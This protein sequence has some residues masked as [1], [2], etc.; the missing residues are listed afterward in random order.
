MSLQEDLPCS[1]LSSEVSSLSILSQEAPEQELLPDQAS[2]ASRA[3]SPLSTPRSL[4]PGIVPKLDLSPAIALHM[5]SL[6]GE[7]EEEEEP[8]H[9]RQEKEEEGA[10]LRQAAAM[11]SFDDLS[12]PE[13]S[14][15]A[16]EAAPVAPATTAA[17]TNAGHSMQD[18]TDDADHASTTSS[19][20]SE[21]LAGHSWE[22]STAGIAQ[23]S[24]SMPAA[25]EASP[26][27]TDE[28]IR[29]ESGET[30]QMASAPNQAESALPPK[31]ADVAASNSYQAAVISTADAKA[32]AVGA[33]SSP[34][35][36]AVDIDRT[37]LPDSSLSDDAAEST[38]MAQASRTL[39]AVN[40]DKSL[41]TASSILEELE[42]SSAYSSQEASPGSTYVPLSHAAEAASAA[43]S[44]VTRGHGDQTE[45]PSEPLLEAD[46][47]QLSFESP[48][49]NHLMMAADAPPLQSE[50][51]DLRSLPLLALTI[52]KKQSEDRE[53]Q[54]LAPDLLAY[55]EAA[56][57]EDASNADQHTLVSSQLAEVAH[58][59]VMSHS[60]AGMEAAGRSRQADNIAAELFDELLDDAVLSMTSTGDSALPMPQPASHLTLLIGQICCCAHRKL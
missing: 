4:R 44:S 45:A 26:S 5:A 23:P 38:A 12:G 8:A 55:A 51:A 2:L 21:S 28:Y 13:D 24:V 52:S 36:T 41:S 27:V 57:T 11:A 22:M 10:T 31:K 3:D 50:S 17:M 25:V 53:Q 29:A 35:A 59:A 33:G 56:M 60:E 15:T 58:T 9:H 49:A 42:V 48:D 37:H 7:E 14:D 46:E 43:A 30:G 19:A 47:V 1:C 16:S 32:R 54:H 39:P 18:V 34:H 20:D 40:S 6:E